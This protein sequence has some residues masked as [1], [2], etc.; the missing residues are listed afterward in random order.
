MTTPRSL[1]DDLR[2]RDDAALQT[3]VRRRPDLALPT[4]GDLGQLAGRSVTSAS[5]ARALDHLTRF[6]LQV[7]EAAVVCDEPFTL[8]QVRS[9]FPDTAQADID[10]QF[11]DLVLLALVWGEPDAW[12]PTIAA[13][14][15][16][17][18]FP[19]GLGP[20]LAV[21]GGG[22]GMIGDPSFKAAERALLSVE[23]VEENVDRM[24]QLIVITIE[25]DVCNDFFQYQLDVADNFTADIVHV[26]VVGDDFGQPFKFRQVV[27]Q[28]NVGNTAE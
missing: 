1:A 4:P 2:G 20:T 6:G 12:R 15:T 11:D 28:V 9:L 17:G 26:T 27:F 25:N 19:A 21:L 10:G 24:L 3:L 14:E 13:R 5:T 22:T 23:Q 8:P 7:L 16:V 18:R